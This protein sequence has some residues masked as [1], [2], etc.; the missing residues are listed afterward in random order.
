MVII[1]A[2]LISGDP[3]WQIVHRGAVV[4]I[5]PLFVSEQ[6]STAFRRTVLQ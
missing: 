6:E 1:A 2:T 5:Q 4:Y 3:K